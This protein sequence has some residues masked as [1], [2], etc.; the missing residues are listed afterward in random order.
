MNSKIRLHK[1]RKMLF[2]SKSEKRNTKT[3][4]PTNTSST[5]DH[6]E[7]TG[8]DSSES[9][10]DDEPVDQFGGSAMDNEIC[11]DEVVKPQRP[12]HDRIGHERYQNARDVNVKFSDLEIGSYC[13]TDCGG[14]LYQLDPGVMIRI[15]GRS[16]ADI[17]RYHIEKL[18]CALYGEVFSAELPP[19][20]SPDKYDSRFKAMLATQRYFTATPLYRQEHY[21]GLQQFPLWN[22]ISCLFQFTPMLEL[23]MDPI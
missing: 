22:R 7:A 5:S 23:L 4:K 21:Q 20:V 9:K 18:R 1:L 12:G 15:Y 17:V 10:A 11:G 19:E 6:D 14:K 16:E 8:N 2:G 13:P 3:Y